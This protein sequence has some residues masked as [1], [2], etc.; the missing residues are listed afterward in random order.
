[1]AKRPA[2]RSAKRPT[3]RRG[4]RRTERA[5]K[6]TPATKAKSPAAAPRAAQA[7]AASSHPSSAPPSR[8]EQA[9]AAP[10]ERD[11]LLHLE[12][13]VQ[14]RI[15]G[16]RDEIARV[17][18]TIRIRRIDLDF[19]PRRPDGA[20]LLV[21]PA[22]VGKTEFACAFAEALQGSDEEIL[23]FDLADYSEEEDLADLVVTPLA[24]SDDTF[25]EGSLTSRVR[26]N[27]RAII[28]L[29]G[30]EHAHRTFYR[31]LLHI[32][33]RGHITDAQGEV[34]FKETILFAT[35]R[36]H[37]EL[38]ETVE[39]IGFNRE[40]ISRTERW[41]RMLEER[42]S[43]ELINAF[44]DVLYFD[45][46]SL[47]DVRQI[48]RTKVNAVLARLRRRNRGIEISDRVYDTFIR[49]E[50]VR[51]QGARHLN[52][53]LEEQLF[54]PL[55]KYLL[56]HTKARHIRVDVRGGRVVIR[57]TAS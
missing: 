36:L 55:S 45:T 17:A 16:R 51:T 22:G 25:V 10:A 48:A 27:P 21:G 57:E 32:L 23:L 13:R 31:L 47:A 28:L 37:P 42:F 12:E 15:V 52:R 43:S 35:T 19:R 30:L 2:K 29:R 3:Q 54:N 46:L 39:Q 38:T 14:T 53:A 8:E 7:D 56:A 50:E 9:A 49:E 6:R 40:A 1:M 41:R 33:D 34:G 5:S 4:E 20:F 26:E 44:N 24:G 11:V 18:K